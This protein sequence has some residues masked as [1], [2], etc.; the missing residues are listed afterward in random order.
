[1][2]ILPNG[3]AVCG[4]THHAEW[5]QSGLVHD[6]FMAEQVRSMIDPSRWSVNVG[7]HIGSLCRVMIDAG[8]PVIAYEPNVEAIE[9]LLHNCPELKGDWN[10]NGS[11]AREYAIAST[12]CTRG[13]QRSDNAGASKII[14]YVE[15]E[16]IQAV[17]LDSLGHYDIGF[18]L[19]DCEGWE[20][21]LLL[22][23]V[24]IITRCRPKM[25][26][27]VSDPL[28]R[29]AGSSEDELYAALDELRYETQV[30][31]PQCARGRDPQYD[32]RCLPL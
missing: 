25:I 1:M 11:F 30:I 8:G 9:C 12:R 28:L 20:T 31:Q 17:A 4:T 21:E 10:K 32:L 3:V 13:I 2:T 16:A 23:A 24:E 22:G 6:P 26:L 14:P 7:A 27:E 15:G 19:A 5:C 18:I 29:E